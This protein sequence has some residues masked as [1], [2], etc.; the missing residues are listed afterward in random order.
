MEGVIEVNFV[1][2]EDIFLVGDNA[3]A[4]TSTDRLDKRDWSGAVND[5][6]DGTGFAAELL[7][8]FAPRRS[9]IDLGTATGTVPLLCAG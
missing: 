1:F 8:E 5:Y 7:R 6:T 4:E 9:L 3:V 2:D